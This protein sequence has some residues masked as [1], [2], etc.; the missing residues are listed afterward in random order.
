MV[1]AD[2][3]RLVVLLLPFL[4]SG[5]AIVTVAD[6]AVSVAATTVKAATTVVGT[7]V[8]VTAAGVRAVIP[9]DQEEEEKRKELPQ[10][11]K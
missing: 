10:E 11:K 4:Y 1:K 5:C 2:Q 3:M 8:E 6:A 7:A 9:K